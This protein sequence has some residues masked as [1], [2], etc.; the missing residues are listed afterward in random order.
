MTDFPT[1]G[2]R[3]RVIGSR[4]Y[5]ESYLDPEETTSTL[6]AVGERMARNSYLPK[7]GIIRFK[8]LKLPRT[9]EQTAFF[10]GLAEWCYFE[11]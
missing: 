4:H 5:Y 10:R 6:R 11:P 1:E 2:S 8:E 3:V 7:D 9:S